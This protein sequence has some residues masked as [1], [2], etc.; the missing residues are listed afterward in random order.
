[1]YHYYDGINKIDLD[2][3]IAV[4]HFQCSNEILA[5]AGLI[6]SQPANQPANQQIQLEDSTTREPSSTNILNA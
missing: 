6:A 3:K 5:V 1:M 2:F 4:Q